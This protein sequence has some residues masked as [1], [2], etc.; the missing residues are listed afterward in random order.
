M[1]CPPGHHGLLE[2]HRHPRRIASH[3][4]RRVHQHGIGSQFHGRGC[5]GW[6]TE[7]GIHHHRHGGLFDDNLEA[8][9]R[10]QAARTAN[11][12]TER[13]HGCAT[14]ILQALR[15]DR[16]GMD[17]RQYREPFLDQDLGCGKRLNR[18]R[19]QVPRVRMNL[20]LEP[21]CCGRFP[22]Q[23]RQATGLGSIPRPAGVRQQPV[24]VP[25]NKVEDVGKPIRRPGQVRSAQRHRDQLGPARRQRR[26]HLF[27]GGELPSSQDQP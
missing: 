16:I 2:R 26:C 14:H 8:R 23:P 3:R 11:R 27:A 24:P 4:D 6:R 17:V 10:L 9:P 5:L 21:A 7:T 25:V 12:R 22:A 18:I 20:K 1:G 13:H 19:Q 15:Q